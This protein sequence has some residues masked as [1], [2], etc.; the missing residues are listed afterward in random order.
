YQ[1]TQCF[2]GNRLTVGFDWFRYGG[3]AWTDY[4]KG[5][6]AGTRKD[7]VDKHDNEVAGY[8]DFRQDFGTWLTL[9][10]G[11]RVDHHSQV[12][13]EWIPQ[14]GLAFHLPKN[15]ELKVSAGKGFRYPTLREMYMFPPQNPNLKPE[16][17][18]NY[19]IAFSQRLLGGRL[20]YGINI[21]YI[22]G[23]NLIVT[24]PNPNGTGRLNQNS[25]K[26]N[27]SGIEVQAA[28]RINPHWS[29]DAN[30][31]FLHMKNPVIA[32]PEHKLYA[33][34]TF[35]KGFCSLSTGVQYVSGLYTSVS[36]VKKEDF[37][38]WN[39]R[40][41][42]HVAKWVDIWLRGEN[43]L[44][45]KYEINDGYPM[46]RTTVMAGL[47]INIQYHTKKLGMGSQQYELVRLD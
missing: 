22:N 32:A 20:S 1:S 16:S 11:F 4:V 29:V 46:P 7:L 44:A 41:S 23:K 30:Y 34:G 36:P 18:W 9:N 45:Q 5:P 38:L 35:S 14:A 40:A 8:V 33:G 28:Y 37:V 3:Q 42:F 47:N 21:F 17:M 15:I 31:S 43:L 6:D 26:I 25:G 13:T 27:N 10:A 24:L 19:E 2:K 12:G 39:L